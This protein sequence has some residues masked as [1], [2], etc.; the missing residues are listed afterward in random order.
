[1]SNANEILTTLVSHESQ[2][3][4]YRRLCRELKVHVNMA[5]KLLSEFYNT[6]KSACQA[7]FLV[8]G[9]RDSS[10]GS[11]LQVNLVPES[12]LDA[13]QK[14]LENSSFHVY[15]V[16]PRVE[17]TREA[18]IMANVLASSIRDISEH[19]AVN[20][21]VTKVEGAEIK[22]APKPAVDLNSQEEPIAVK[23]EPTPAKDPK[24]RAKKSFFGR[25]A[26]AKPVPK[27]P[28]AETS[29][30]QPV[31]ETEAESKP[32]VEDMFMDDSESPPP[33][34]EESLVSEAMD[35]QTDEES[36]MNMQADGDSQAKEASDVEMVDA[37]GSQDN[38][39][40]SQSSGPSRVRKRRKVRKIKHTKNSRGMLVSQAVDEWESYSETE[41]DSDVNPK[42]KPALPKLPADK[43]PTSKSKAAPQRNILSFFGKK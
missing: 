23:A 12:E 5:K 17:V 10:S 14:E 41:S 32:R 1:M 21:S 19:G 20:S 18:L 22:A 16:G 13:A 7:T 24:S 31:V 4:T 8:T 27:A 38:Q 43:K 3:V 33:I 34:K 29:Q 6:H 39:N 37:N 28:A 15:S 9:T 40:E 25:S 2:I 35:T 11:E 42:H 36:A 30:P 26:N